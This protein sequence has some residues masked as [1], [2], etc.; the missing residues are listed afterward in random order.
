MGRSIDIF[1][2]LFL[3]LPCIFLLEWK[4]SSS[5]F[6]GLRRGAIS[7]SIFPSPFDRKRKF[8]EAKLARNELLIRDLLVPDIGRNLNFYKSC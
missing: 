1:V 8:S 2:L 6:D 4:I 3:F 5:R 7:I